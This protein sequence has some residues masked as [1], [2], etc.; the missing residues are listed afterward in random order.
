MGNEVTPEFI[1]GL[2]SEQKTHEDVRAILQDVYPGERDFQRSQLNVFVKNM[3]FHHVHK[4]IECKKW[5][6]SLLKR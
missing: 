2:F 4:K 5:F 1:A 3:A 6:R